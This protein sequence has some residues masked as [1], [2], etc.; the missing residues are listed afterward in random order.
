VHRKANVNGSASFSDACYVSCLS[1]GQFFLPDCSI[2]TY[3][4]K[5]S[6]GVGVVLNVRGAGSV[7]QGRTTGIYAQIQLTQEEPQG[8]KLIMNLM[9]MHV[10]SWPLVSRSESTLLTRSAHLI[11]PPTV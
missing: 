4:Y 8:A 2:T 1:T 9:L 6:F 10:L 11:H 7:S 3:D 5:A